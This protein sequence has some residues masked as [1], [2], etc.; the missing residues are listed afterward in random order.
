MKS[1]FCFAWL[2]CVVFFC[3]IEPCLAGEDWFMPGEPSTPMVK[4]WPAGDVRVTD[5]TIAEVKPSMT[6]APNGDLYTVVEELAEQWIRLYRSTDGGDTWV[7]IGGYASGDDSR[8]P[9]VAYGEHT[10]G[11]KWVYIAYEE[12]DATGVNRRVR[13]V[14]VDENGAVPTWTTIDGPYMMNS[15]SDEVHPQIITDFVDWGDLYYVYVTYATF[16]IDGYPIKSSRS[17]DRGTTWSTPLDVTG[18]SQLTAW[19]ARPEIAYGSSGLFITFVKPGWTGG[20]WSNQIWVSKSTSAGS[21]FAAPVQL[22]TTT[23]NVFHPAVAVAHGVNSVVVAF[24]I[25]LGSDM[26][27]AFISSTDGGTTWDPVVRLLPWTFDHESSVDLTVSNSNGH[28]HAAYKHEATGGG[29][30]KIWYT[31]ASTADPASWSP[32]VPINEGETASG[33]SFYPR[34]TIAVM[35]GLPSKGEAA[36]AW[37]D[38]RGTFYDAYFGTAAIFVDGFESGDASVWS[39]SSFQVPISTTLLSEDG[40]DFSERTSGDFTHGDFYFLYQSGVSRFFANNAGMNGLVDVGVTTGSLEDVTVPA[41]GYSQFGVQAILNHTYVSIAEDGED[42]YYIIFR[43]TAVSSTET[44]L[45]WI[46]V[47]R[48]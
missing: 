43:V 23:N 34:P 22:T 48:P 27:A 42:G 36:I 47:Y 25:D 39:S 5:P 31:Q 2:F 24:T 14:R 7:L 21:S 12:V 41:S 19:P 32:V 46:Y 40:Y 33:I 6:S 8:N 28:F 20:S 13:V 15:T 30:D 35:P 44:T 10:N 45:E 11:E 4:S 1:R 38:W 18:S 17:Q 37:T 3:S 16:S 29:S 26:D 9:S